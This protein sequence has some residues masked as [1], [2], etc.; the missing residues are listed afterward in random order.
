MQLS[1][2]AGNFCVFTYCTLFFITGGPSRGLGPFTDTMSLLL[3]FGNI[4]LW[5][6]SLWFS[7]LSAEYNTLV[8]TLKQG[9]R[10]S[11]SL[12]NALNSVLTRIMNT[13]K[14]I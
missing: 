2:L 12:Y 11:F 4:L 3:A 9:E 6:N 5:G 7:K 13:E 10:A 14:V 1:V 8:V